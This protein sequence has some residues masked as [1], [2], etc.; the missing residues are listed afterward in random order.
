MRLISEVPSRNRSGMT[1]SAPA[2][3][4]A[5]GSPQALAWNIGTMGSVTSSLPTSSAL[6]VHVAMA[7]RKLERWL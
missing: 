2:I 5:Y 6:L 4:A 3:S 1:R 7:C